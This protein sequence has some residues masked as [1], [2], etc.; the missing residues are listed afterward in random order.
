MQDEPGG[1]GGA[2]AK[3]DRILLPALHQ[4]SITMWIIDLKLKGQVLNGTVET[5]MR[6]CSR[7]GNLPGSL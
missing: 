4:T 1:D 5:L 2:T 7:I 6:R 3:D